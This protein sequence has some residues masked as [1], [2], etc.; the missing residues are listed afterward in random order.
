MKKDSTKVKKGRGWHGDPAA[1]ARVG[2]MGGKATAQE[3][4]DSSFYHDIGSIGGKVSSG[5]F[6]NNPQR[7]KEAGKKG[8]KSRARRS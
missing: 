5:N 2:R 6:K 4:G 3:Y 7:A 8:G 1:H